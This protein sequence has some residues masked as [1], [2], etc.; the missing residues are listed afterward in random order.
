MNRAGIVV[1]VGVRVALFAATFLLLGQ[2]TPHSARIT[3]WMVDA[4][5]AETYDHA[6]TAYQH[7]LILSGDHPTIYALL[8]QTSLDYGY[9]GAA[10]TYLHALSDRMP[11]NTDYAA[12]QL[13]LLKRDGDTAGETA[14]L[15]VA[16]ANDDIEPDAL[17]DL[18]EQ[19]MAR[20][21]W[22]AATVTLTRL[23]ASSP[24]DSEAAY[25]L[26]AL[27]ATEDV[28]QAVSYLSRAAADPQWA[29]SANAIIDALAL[30]SQQTL[31]SAHTSLGVTLIGLGEWAFAERALSQALAVNAINP[32]A[33]AYRGFVRDQQGRD[34]L[35]DIQ[36]AQ[37]MAPNDPL[38]YYLLGLHWRTAGD[39]N[40]G[41]DAFV[42]AYLLDEQ[43][44]A[45]AVEVAISKQYLSDF[46]GAEKWYLTA[47]ELEPQSLEWQRALAAFYADTGYRLESDGLDFIVQASATFKADADIAAS[48][49]WAYYQLGDAE[50]AY[51]A[52]NNAMS[53]NNALARV[54]YYFGVVLEQRGDTGGAADSYWYIVDRYG[55]DEGYGL[56]A[57]RALERLGY[58]P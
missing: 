4:R 39:N 30:Y 38:I 11:W 7:A 24:R 36:S 17:R 3:R 10:Q 20:R 43:N 13:E 22:D 21:D 35:A 58:A 18:A 16:A 40:A 1:R 28:T 51:E 19:Q 2:L 29:N 41:H 9:D 50:L 44:P 12:W 32:P 55:A 27:L 57:A 54:R 34:G 46:E 52:L 56:L 5:D 45:L 8:V 42:H 25:W 37:A 53:L 47:I 26:G 15:Y 33:L 48:L 6:V 14:A 23:V 49:G 31:S